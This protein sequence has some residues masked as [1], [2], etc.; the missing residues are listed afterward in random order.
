MG[1]YII[2]G[3]K[4]LNGTAYT[5][6]A[7]NSVLP[8]LSASVLTNDL[9]VL[10]NCPK[11]SDTY[12][13]LEI[14]KSLG[15][16][17][18]T[19][20]KILITDTSS[21]N[22]TELPNYLVKKMRSSVIFAGSL[23]SRFGEAII[24][25]PG[26]CELG[27]RPINLHLDA[28]KK[29]G[30]NI[31]YDNDKIICKAKRLIGTEIN[32]PI[33]SVGATQN[34][35]LA[36]VLAEGTTTINN[37]AKEP[38]IIDLKNYLLKAGAKIEG[39]GTDT[40]K[41]EGVKSLHYASHTIIPDRI[42]A[43]TF[44]CAAAITGGEIVLENAPTCYLTAFLEKLKACGCRIYTEKNKL[45]LS[46]PKALLPVSITKTEPYP[47]FP[48]DLH[49]PFMSVLACSSGTSILSETIFNNRT[50]HINELIKMGADITIKDNHTFEIKGKPQ[51]FGTEVSAEDL[52]GGASLILAGLAADGITVVKNSKHIERGYENIEKTLKALGADIE[53]EA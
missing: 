2:K 8:I 12:I 20:N 45:F 32:L 38:E 24:Y 34:I 17:V 48:T 42:E 40:I 6:G 22:K 31:I 33:K 29:M 39:A 37:C 13:A 51:L 43:G 28:F 53:F 36:A 50:K 27:S 15:A 4:A 52:R 16:C 19:E 35:I 46:S 9:S 25:S 14:L 30:A 10:Y 26:G 44:L 3:G 23:L 18:N 49:P 7:K 5:N 41:I 47:G 11:I 1:K 21:I